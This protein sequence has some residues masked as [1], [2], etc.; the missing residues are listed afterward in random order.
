MIEFNEIDELLPTSD[1][2]V[3]KLLGVES[4]VDPDQATL[5]MVRAGQVPHLRI[6]R[7]VRFSLP[8]LKKWAAEKIA[9]SVAASA[10]TEPA[11][12]STNAL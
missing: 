9:N 1:P 5:R 10:A 8:A 2:A 6:G 12:V 4:C 7:R 11:E 3:R